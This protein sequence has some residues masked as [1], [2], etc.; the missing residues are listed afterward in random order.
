[1]SE[2]LVHMESGVA[3]VTLNRPDR[4][5]AWTREMSKQLSG[6]MHELDNDRS[7]S[8]IVLTGAGR[9]FCAGLDIQRFAGSSSEPPAPR[10][11]WIERQLPSA[12]VKPVVAAINGAAVGI[13]LAYAVHC[14]VRFVS[15]DAKVGFAFSRRG[16]APEIGMSAVLPRVVGQSIAADLLMSGR[17]ITGSEAAALGLASEAL[18]AA[19]VVTRAMEWA[20]D[21]AAN[22][23]PASVGA[24]KEFLWGP[25]RVADRVAIQAEDELVVR[26]GA[27]DEARE[28]MAAF[29]EKR[30]PSW[31]S[32]H[33]EGAS[34]AA[35][36]YERT[37]DGARRTH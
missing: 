6:A 27:S 24:M 35:V 11:P 13:G 25:T 15:S 8:A 14:D 23:S 31:H 4:L 10:I 19:D 2:V 36:V 22:C 29:V 9:A 37:S 30:P 3:T 18:P 33:A 26:F 20:R 16:L 1:M 32:L 28:G 5:N 17:L 34:A 7:V 21:V 12:M